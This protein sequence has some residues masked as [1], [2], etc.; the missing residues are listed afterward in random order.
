MLVCLC[1]C[2]WGWE[3]GL[4]LWAGRRLSL[5]LQPMILLLR[6]AATLE[7]VTVVEVHPRRMVAVLPAQRTRSCRRC[8]R[9]RLLKVRSGAADLPARDYGRLEGSEDW[10]S[11]SM[12]TRRRACFRCHCHCRCW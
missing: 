2:S 3:D 8:V 1:G 9:G 6:S 4:G 12:S 10:R 7:L 11:T 5:L